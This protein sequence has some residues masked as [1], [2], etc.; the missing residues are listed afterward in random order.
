MKTL[1]AIFLG[2][3]VVAHLAGATHGVVSEKTG[4]IG[5]E[6]LAFGSCN[7]QDDPQPLWSAVVADN[8]DLWVWLGDNI[9]A[10]TADTN[11]MRAKYRAQLQR[12]KYQ[13][14]LRVCP[15]IG[16]WDDHDYG[17]NNGGVEFESKRESQAL[18][19]DFLG[20]PAGTKRRSQ[21][22]VYASYTYG[23]PH[24]QVQ[25]ILLDTRF[26]REEPGPDADI[27]GSV[28]W[29]W[30]ERTLMESSAAVHIVASSIQV[31]PED[32]Q[33]EKWANF[34]ASRERLF[35]TIGRT[36]TTG[37]LFLSGD[38]HLAE[39]SRMTH[40]KVAYPL[41]EIT[42]S[43]MTHSYTSLTEEPNRHRLG[44]FHKQLNYG[45]LDFRWME[46]S[47][48]VELQIKDRD[49]AVALFEV[50]EYPLTGHE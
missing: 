46:R 15:V 3:A 9:Y 28:Q 43:G 39:I 14:L 23:P 16:T 10:D 24:R 13:Q 12:P 41:Y 22:G 34:P 27:L 38:R 21:D 20:E 4:E 32:H 42:S 36:K 8:P 29:S 47:V 5:I 25:V 18:L 44:E 6:R 35:G 48:E 49:G 30:L 40:P 50:V 7:R 37:V 33:Y 17:K 19:L 31:L 45:I 26:H 11:V 1:K 2:I